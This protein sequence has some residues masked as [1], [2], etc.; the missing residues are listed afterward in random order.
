M[1]QDIQAHDGPILAMKFSLDGQYLVSSGEDVIVQLWQ[2]VDNERSNELEIPEKDPSCLYFTV[3][4]LFESKPLFAD[5]EKMCK[6]SSPRKSL[7]IACVMSPPKVFQI[8]EKPLHK[9]RGHSGDILDLSWS[10]NNVSKLFQCQ[11]NFLD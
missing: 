9:F 2:V 1:G 8:L 10:R 3:N 6:V 4:H 5:K 7:D 11:F